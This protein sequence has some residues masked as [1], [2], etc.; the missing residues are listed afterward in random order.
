MMDTDAAAEWRAQLGE[1]CSEPKVTELSEY[2][3]TLRF[4]DG[5]AATR[6]EDITSP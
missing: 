6:P 2:Y 5:L 4:N 1:P 3:E